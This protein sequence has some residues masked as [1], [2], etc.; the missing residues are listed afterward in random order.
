MHRPCIIGMYVLD[1]YPSL[2]CVAAELSVCRRLGMRDGSRKS[3]SAVSRSCAYFCKVRKIHCPRRACREFCV[4]GPV[5]A[6][7][8]DAFRQSGR[9]RVPTQVHRCID[10]AVTF[11]QLV[12]SARGMCLHRHWRHWEYWD[13][14]CCTR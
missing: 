14:L 7:W 1:H 4:S 8:Q 6:L 2:E 3:S 13:K 11:L 5:D 12:G 10:H 9:E